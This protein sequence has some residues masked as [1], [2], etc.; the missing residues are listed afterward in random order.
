M[1]EV[2]DIEG[3]RNPNRQVPKAGDEAGD[4]EEGESPMPH[5]GQHGPPPPHSGAGSKSAAI[6]DRRLVRL[7]GPMIPYCGGGVQLGL[8]IVGQAI[9]ATIG[10]LR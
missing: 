1:R 6:I 9:A 4:Q 2:I 5:D 7:S 8:A 3:E 10:I